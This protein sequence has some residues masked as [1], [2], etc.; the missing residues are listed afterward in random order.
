MSNAC[1]RWENSGVFLG[2]LSHISLEFL[3]TI[4][5][6]KNQNP[7]TGKASPDQNIRPPF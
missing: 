4:S 1:N 7:N 5:S 2:Y 6:E 3:D